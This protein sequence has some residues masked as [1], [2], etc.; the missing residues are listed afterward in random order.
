MVVSGSEPGEC[1]RTDRGWETRLG[2]FLRLK[3]K[4]EQNILEKKVVFLGQIHVSE[5][6]FLS[7]QK[8]K[9]RQLLGF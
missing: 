6:N 9:P 1:I 2:F 3:R 7:S 5:N 4:N 8:P